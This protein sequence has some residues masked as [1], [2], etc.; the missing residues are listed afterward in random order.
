MCKFNP[1]TFTPNPFASFSC[2]LP[3]IRSVR[4]GKHIWTRQATSSL[5]PSSCFCSSSSCS[6]SLSQHTVKQKAQGSSPVFFPNPFQLRMS[7][8]QSRV[9]RV[10]QLYVSGQE[11]LWRES[12]YLQRKKQT[13]SSSVDRQGLK[14]R[15]TPAPVP[16]FDDGYAA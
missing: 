3:S 16:L 5:L 9:L 8:V 14:V 7:V 12:L 4:K 1:R 11:P 6:S 13:Y 10:S 2:S 15:N